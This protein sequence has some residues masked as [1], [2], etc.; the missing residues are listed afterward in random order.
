MEERGE[1]EVT[2]YIGKS[3]AKDAPIPF[4]CLEVEI[5][6]ADVRPCGEETLA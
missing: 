3:E 6:F 2:G 5:T 4:P 1:K